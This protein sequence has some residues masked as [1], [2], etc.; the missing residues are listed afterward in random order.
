MVALGFGLAW[1]SYL[2]TLLQGNV[3]APGPK[4]S[5]GAAGPPVST[6]GISVT[7]PQ[8]QGL[9]EMKPGNKPLL[10]SD[11]PLFSPTRVLLVSLVLLAVLVPLVPL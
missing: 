2:D 1:V 7:T 3:G 8:R 6:N 5:R 10:T 9:E 11:H 4:G